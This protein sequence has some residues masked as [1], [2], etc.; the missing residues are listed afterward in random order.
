M[1]RMQREE[2]TVKNWQF[3]A[4]GLSLI[5]LNVTIVLFLWLVMTL[6]LK[7]GDWLMEVVMEVEVTAAE[8]EGKIE[9]LKCRKYIGE[10]TG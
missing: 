1:W 3:D 10:K 7:Q 8:V 2:E 5:C 4:F 6:N 9:N